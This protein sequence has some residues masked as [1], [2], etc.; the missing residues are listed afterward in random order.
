MGR[1]KSDALRIIRN[2]A[3]SY[4]DNLENKNVLFVSTADNKAETFE[5]S[6]LP[7]NFLHLTGIITKH[8]STTFYSLTL[9]GRLREQDIS[10]ADDGTTE[11]KLDVL[12]S[13]MKIHLT[14]KMLGDY[15]HSQSLLVT[16]KLAGTVT[17]ALG[18]KKDDK[19]YL[20]NTS[21]KTDIR[22]VSQKPVKRIVATF[23]K[24]F[25]DP[26]YCEMSYLAKGFTIEDELLLSAIQ[27]TVDLDK[28]V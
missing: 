3:I 27:G 23:V 12:D 18:F 4:R 8:N 19:Y 25:D 14:A 11:M 9:R 2:C 28:I 5:V 24:R 6:F 13:L 1:T 26:L 20:P 7:R 16:D 21:L 15:N 10:F 22:T 17:S